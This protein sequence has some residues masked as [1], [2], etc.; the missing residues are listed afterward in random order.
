M[1]SARPSCW[2]SA[3]TWWST[4]RCQLGALVAFFLYLNRFFQPIQLL[5][6]QYNTFQQGQASVFKLRDL[7]DTEPEVKE[8][9]D[10]IELPPIEGEIVFDHVS[11]G[12]DPDRPVLFDVDLRIAPG[13]T[14]AFVG[15]DGSRQVDAGQAGDPLLRPDRRAGS[16]STGT[17]S[18]T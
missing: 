7:V 4:T 11:F 12:Y 2:P 14:V 5:V 10:A 18:A 17:T 15:P 16:S 8:A 6:Q 1:S 13:E 9:A 3:A